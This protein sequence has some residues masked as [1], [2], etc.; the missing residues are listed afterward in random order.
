[1]PML[2]AILLS[3][4]STWTLKSTLQASRYHTTLRSLPSTFAITWF[5]LMPNGLFPTALLVRR[6]TEQ[7]QTPCL[8]GSCGRSPP[9]RCTP[10]PPTNNKTIQPPAALPVPHPVAPARTVRSEGI[11]WF[12]RPCHH[13]HLC[14]AYPKSLH[15][16]RLPPRQHAQHL[17]DPTYLPRSHLTIPK[18]MQSTNDSIEPETACPRCFRQRRASRP[19]DLPRWRRHK[20]NTCSP[21]APPSQ[22]GLHA[23]AAPTSPLQTATKKANGPGPPPG[24]ESADCPYPCYRIRTRAVLRTQKTRVTFCAPPAA[25]AQHRPHG[26]TAPGKSVRRAAATPRIPAENSKFRNQLHAPLHPAPSVEQTVQ[27][28]NPG[29]AC[30]PTKRILPPR[31]APAA[32]SPGL[33]KPLHLLL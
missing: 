12:K 16:V 24:H 13:P 9:L 1:M 22:H 20:E 25:A 17:T 11:Q 8:R 4:A 32:D 26:Q 29:P 31:A 21:S 3:A 6:R 5:L 30:L 15:R 33:V 10:H 23:H 27:A 28:A 2:V 7:L 14:S 19:K 18:H